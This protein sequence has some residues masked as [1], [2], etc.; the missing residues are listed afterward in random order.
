MSISIFI[1]KL[2]KKFI[3]IPNKRSMHSKPTSYIGGL[4]I[5]F[6]YVCSLPLF[7]VVDNIGSYK[8]VEL[9]TY[10]ANSIFISAVYSSIIVI[11]LLFILFVDNQY[12]SSQ[13]KMLTILTSLGYALPGAVLGLS[14][15]IF[16]RILDVLG[17][18]S[19]GFKTTVFPADTAPMIGDIDS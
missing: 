12:K 17:E 11:L 19:E 8:L 9:T 1:S 14:L 16:S 3:D 7:N 18:C 2:S 5:S 6:I 10:T 15:I 4:A 13:S